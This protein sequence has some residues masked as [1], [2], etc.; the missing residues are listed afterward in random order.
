MVQLVISG[1]ATGSLK[2]NFSFHHIRSAAWFAGKA[3]AMEESLTWPPSNEQHFEHLALSTS[4]V[5]ASVAAVE[6]YLNEVYLDIADGNAD[7]VGRIGPMLD[8]VV[9]LWDTAERQSLLRKFEWL[10]T[11]AT[12]R[13]IDRG[14]SVYQNIVDVVAVRNELVHYKPEWSHTPT[15]SERLEKRLKGRFPL[16]PLSA[17]GQFFI[18]Y[19]CLGAGCARWSVESAFAFVSWFATDLGVRHSWEGFRSQVI[20]LLGVTAV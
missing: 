16:N 12:S 8:V 14:S 19:R 6:A 13:T 15:R 7:Q 18:P 17:S 4:A 11:L 2:T 10:F 20:P 1:S 9:Q 5:I 3:R